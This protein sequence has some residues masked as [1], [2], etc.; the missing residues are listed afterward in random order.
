MY[1]TF[2]ITGSVFEYNL[3]DQQ[4]TKT[5]DCEHP[6]FCSKISWN[7]REISEHN[8]WAASDDAMSS[9]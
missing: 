3:Y 2:R 5:L 1:V 8:R 9:N 7:E 4:M 6:L